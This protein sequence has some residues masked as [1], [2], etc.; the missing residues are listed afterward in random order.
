MQIASWVHPCDISALGQTGSLFKF[1]LT[2]TPFAVHHLKQYCNYPF[3]LPVCHLPLNYVAAHVILFQSFS[4]VAR[5]TLTSTRRRKFALPI[6][7]RVKN[8]DMFDLMQA[9]NGYALKWGCS[10][11]DEGVVILLLGGMGLFEMVASRN[12]AEAFELSK[13]FGRRNVVLLLNKLFV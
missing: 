9:E 7:A 5:F 12:V 4:M 13:Q 2:D 11:G 10:W 6:L 3:V 1:L 8:T